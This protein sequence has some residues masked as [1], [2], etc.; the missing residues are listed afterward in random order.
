M[1]KIRRMPIQ[2]QCA[3]NTRKKQ[4]VSKTWRQK[5]VVRIEAVVV[6]C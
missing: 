2:D 1:R 5:F 4:P 6:Q 3:K